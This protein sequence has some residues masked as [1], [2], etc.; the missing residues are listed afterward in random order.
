MNGKPVNQAEKSVS[1]T[2]ESVVNAKASAKVAE[3]APPVKAEVHNLTSQDRFVLKDTNN[4]GIPDVVVV[5]RY[6]PKAAAAQ[7]EREKYNGYHAAMRA[8][9]DEAARQ[10]AGKSALEVSAAENVAEARAKA[11]WKG[12]TPPES[13]ESKASVKEAEDEAAKKAAIA[14]E[15]DKLRNG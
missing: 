15:I 11:E 3:G 12:P 5:E 6:D 4:D 10:S 2:E 13:P 8:A 1:P 9:R 7:A 14:A